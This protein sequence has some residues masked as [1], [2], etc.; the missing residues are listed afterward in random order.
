MTTARLTRVSLFFLAS[1]GLILTFQNCSKVQATD[2]ASTAAQFST[3]D[4]EGPSSS[5]DHFGTEQGGPISPLPEGSTNLTPSEEGP[6]CQAKFHVQYLL[7]Q[8]I[9]AGLAKDISPLKQNLQMQLIQTGKV[10]SNPVSLKVQGEG[11]CTA[12]HGTLLESQSEDSKVYQDVF[13]VA[14]ASD[15]SCA[16]KDGTLDKDVYDLVLQTLNG[17]DSVDFQANGDLVIK[18]GNTTVVFVPKH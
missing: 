16:C 3:P 2:L 7:N 8:V 5:G 18:A 11:L 12:F 14:A 6:A 15:H 9:V 1:L 17:S 10:C 13:S 4:G